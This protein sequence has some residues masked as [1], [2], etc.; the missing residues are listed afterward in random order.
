MMVIVKLNP[1]LPFVH[2]FIHCVCVIVCISREIRPLLS[3]LLAI[4]TTLTVLIINVVQCLRSS[5]LGMPQTF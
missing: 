1:S 2:S 4:Y 5:P 3:L